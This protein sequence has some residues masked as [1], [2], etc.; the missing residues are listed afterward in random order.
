M[1]RAE[2]YVA[3]PDDG[4]R[5]RPL[6]TEGAD[7]GDRFIDINGSGF[8]HELRH[9]PTV[10]DMTFCRQAEHRPGRTAPDQVGHVREPKLF[11]PA[12]GSGT[13]VSM[14]IEAVD[15]HR[16]GTVDVGD[17]RSIQRLQ[18]QAHGARQV[19]LDEDRVRQN[20]EQE[21]VALHHPLGTGSIDASWHASVM[22]DPITPQTE[23]CMERWT[24]LVVDVSA[25]APTGIGCW[26]TSES[27]RA[28]MADKH[29]P[30]VRATAAADA[31]PGAATPDRAR[32]IPI[33]DYALLSDCHTAALVSRDG[34]IDWWCPERFDRPS[35]FARLL[36]HDAGHWTVRPLSR[37]DPVRSYVPGT[38]VVETIF[39]VPTGEIRLYDGLAL[40]PGDR[41]HAIGRHVP[42]VMFRV[43]EGCSGDVEVAMDLVVRPDY[44]RHGP[45]RITSVDDDGRSLLIAGGGEV[46]MFRSSVGVEIDE[47]EGRVSARAIVRD[48]GSCWFTLG[49]RG[50]L[51]DGDTLRRETTAG[52]QSWSALHE[53]EGWQSDLVRRSSLV[54]QALTYGPTGA[55]VAAPTSSL[56]EIVGGSANWDYRYAWLRDATFNVRALAEGACVDEADRYFTWMANAAGPD[57]ACPPVVVG[58]GGERDLAESTL[59]HLDGWRGSRPVRIGNGAWDQ[60]QL[61]VPGEILGAALLLRAGDSAFD[62]GNIRF[63]VRLAELVAERWREPDS[64]I[65]EGREGLR[66]YTS[67]KVMCWTALDRGCTLANDLGVAD[68]A[69]RWA[70][71]R[72]SIHAAVMDQSWDGDQ[73]CFTGA[74]GSDHLDASVLLMPLTGFLAADDQRM[75][76][77]IAAIERRLTTDGLVLRWT[78][79]EDEPFITCSFWLAECH[80]L[81]G[82]VDRARE[83]FEAVVRHVNDVGLLSE[84][85]HRDSGELIGNFPQALSHAALIN[86]AVTIDR[87]M[88]RAT[89]SHRTAGLDERID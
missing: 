89:A 2:Q 40:R 50:E 19:L 6:P 55:M 35:W 61:D 67:S 83:V 3:R 72:D 74:F 84:E 87:A 82:N 4:R 15:D 71:E 76:S 7:I 21:N 18:R 8:E 32:S 85:I 20:I 51:L 24:D 78:D 28:A 29:T 73:Q 59:D 88:G 12:R 10:T 52:W 43:V 38:F 25:D 1:Q 13:Q 79:A 11:E 44:G 63:F 9:A 30:P 86:A 77:T 31:S 48:G 70:A 56:P 62:D 49:A 27:A 66:H 17:R 14:L 16:A 37:S 22:P 54:L 36:G 45:A 46:L 53:Y 41:G 39:Q 60:L 81:G 75:V 33:A 68:R 80:A 42:G 57:D 64:G 23:T 47:S 34:S 26:Q 65:W 5:S 69:E 58:L